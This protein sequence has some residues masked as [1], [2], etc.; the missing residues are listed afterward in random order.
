MSMMIMFGG[1]T[2]L[3][4]TA[5]AKHIRHRRVKVL[6]SITRLAEQKSHERFLRK[7]AVHVKSVAKNRS[8]LVYFGVV[9]SF[10]RITV[11]FF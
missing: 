11:S 10:R 2:F 3:G 6:E 5:T 4:F 7:W 9:S 1:K 8:V